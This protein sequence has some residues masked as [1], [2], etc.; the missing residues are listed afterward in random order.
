MDWRQDF[1]GDLSTGDRYYD[2]AKLMHG[3]I[4]SHEI[5]ERELFSANWINGSINYDF[6]RKQKLIECE[7]YFIKWLKGNGYDVKKV[8][9]LTALIYINISALHHQPYSILLY[10]LGK[11]LLYEEIS[12]DADN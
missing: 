2:F 9:T 6:H 12:P 3:L 1:A 11:K 7:S 4:I 10:A 8:R 5:I